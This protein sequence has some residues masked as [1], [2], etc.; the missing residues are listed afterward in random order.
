LLDKG[1]E[2]DKLK[3]PQ[4]ELLL[5]WHEIANSHQPKGN[6]TKMDKWKEIVN[7][8]KASP[9]YPAWTDEDEQKLNH[10]ETSEIDISETAVGRAD[11]TI[12]REMLATF[13]KMNKDDPKGSHWG[14]AEVCRGCL[15][16][17]FR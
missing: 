2:T 13:N 4:L 6:N 3:K 5:S 1:V 12:K 14:V 15:N 8:K 10:L 16:V 17:L 11:C 9:R 7:G